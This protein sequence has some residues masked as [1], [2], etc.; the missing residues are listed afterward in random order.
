MRDIKISISACFEMP[1]FDEGGRATFR[2]GVVWELCRRPL[3]AEGCMYSTV[4][5][6]VN[7]WLPQQAILS[8]V[9]KRE[10][11][12]SEQLIC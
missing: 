7:A 9:A 4:E 3:P 10:R 1:I 8:L 11:K 6:A 2:R 12:Q 5:M